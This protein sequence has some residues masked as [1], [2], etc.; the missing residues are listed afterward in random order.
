[1]K[2]IVFATVVL[3]SATAVYFLS[4]EAF[5]HLETMRL[6]TISAPKPPQQSPM[7]LIL[8]AARRHKLSAA[9]V[10]SIVKAES[11]FRPDAVS[12]KGALGLMQLMP[13]TAADFG[14]DAGVPEQNVEAGTHYLEALLARYSKYKNSLHR[15]I[16]AYNA[17][18]G[19]VDK[20]HGV[21]PFKETR[22]YVT[23]VMQYY[24]QF[25]KSG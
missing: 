13:A 16:A 24:K 19:N 3:C 4:Y 1:M 11:G 10:K 7:E 9:F 17:G 15:A 6:P 14:M 2:R 8:C 25:R 20:Y 12:P 21:P 23:R 5:N 22:N 18:P